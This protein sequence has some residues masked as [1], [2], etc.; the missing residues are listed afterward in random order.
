MAS[1]A[2]IRYTDEM[3]SAEVFG[4]GDALRKQMAERIDAEDVTGYALEKSKYSLVQTGKK[5]KEMNEK[6][7]TLERIENNPIL[8][9]RVLVSQP[10]DIRLPN[11]TNGR[12]TDVPAVYHVRRRT[13]LGVDLANANGELVGHVERTACREWNARYVFRPSERRPD[14]RALH[15]YSSV[16]NCR[17][18]REGTALPA[19]LQQPTVAFP[20]LET[21]TIGPTTDRITYTYYFVGAPIP[22][23]ADPPIN[24]RFPAWV[25]EDHHQGGRV[26]EEGILATLTDR[27]VFA[28][29]IEEAVRTLPASNQRERNDATI[30][31]SL[32][33]M[34]RAY[35]TFVTGQDLTDNTQFRDSARNQSMRGLPEIGSGVDCFDQTTQ[36]VRKM[37]RVEY[38]NWLTHL[39]SIV[40]N[41]RGDPDNTTRFT[42]HN[43]GASRDAWQFISTRVLP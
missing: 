9:R 31:N 4:N 30:G 36:S 17:Q 11:G 6:M 7:N 26:G 42:L 5:M 8:L 3:S 22:N 14:G 39:R 10:C 35:C 32:A 28:A 13:E 20:I 21:R 24:V 29:A 25:S 15:F 33:Q 34:R 2:V 12:L 37:D 19:A 16:E 18:G 1:R 43:A 40:T 27:R 38:D 23:N 41:F